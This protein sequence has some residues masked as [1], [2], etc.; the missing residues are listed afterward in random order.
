M[1]SVLQTSVWLGLVLAMLATTS[2]MKSQPG[3]D[4]KNIS[5]CQVSLFSDSRG[6]LESLDALYPGQVLYSAYDASVAPDF[7]HGKPIADGWK[8]PCQ[9]DD[10]PICQRACELAKTTPLSLFKYYSSGF[11]ED[12]SKPSMIRAF[13]VHDPKQ[14][15]DEL[16]FIPGQA[17]ENAAYRYR[18]E[19]PAVAGQYIGKKPIGVWQLWAPSGEL[20]GFTDYDLPKQGFVRC[21]K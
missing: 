21:R 14:E 1:I 3:G 10:G 11:R 18:P 5:G 13:Y 19:F 9:C 17:S 15:G 12:A 6:L 7:V 2:C 20:L 8:D 16:V 4:A